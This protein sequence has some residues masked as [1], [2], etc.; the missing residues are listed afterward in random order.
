MGGQLGGGG[1]GSLFL[2]QSSGKA[3]EGQRLTS[4]AW[5][6]YFSYIEPMKVGG[7]GGTKKGVL[8]LVSDFENGTSI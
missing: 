7:G 1:E 4:K 5:V 2:L 8:P 6:H 3:R